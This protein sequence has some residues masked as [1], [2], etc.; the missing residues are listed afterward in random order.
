MTDR[1]NRDAA[2]FALYEAH[3]RPMLELA[4]LLVRRPAAAEQVVQDAFTGL[5]VAWPRLQDNE[6]ALTY[7]RQCVVN[8]AR[9]VLRHSG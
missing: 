7:L 3:Y 6:K 2:L 1:E 4:T 5:W 9:S 8:R